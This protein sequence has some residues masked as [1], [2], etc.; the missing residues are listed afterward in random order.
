MRFTIFGGRGFVGNAL[1]KYLISKGY[2]VLVPERDCLNFEGQELGHV[3]YAI[4]LT[5]DFRSRPFETIDAHV[6]LLARLLRNTSFDSWLYISS[7]RVYSGLTIDVADESIPLNVVPNGDGIYNL[8]KLSGEALCLSLNVRNIR[9]VRLANVYGLG[10]SK[11]TFLGSLVNDIL[12]R[13]QPVIFEAPSSSKDYISLVD[14]TTLLEK[15]AIS[16]THRIY[17]VASGN[18]VTHAELA[19]ALEKAFSC[20]VSFDAEAPS[21][22]FPRIDIQ[23]IVSE[24][25]FRPRQL[26]EEIRHIFNETSQH[27]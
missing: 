20:D 11:D 6:C 4:G 8:S 23:R 27:G 22:S 26:L 5:A 9:V 25:G 13:R 1:N 7:T 21:R 24:F 3:I 17:N 14:V 2:E 16:G 18:P 10:Q 12:N 19:K 15:I